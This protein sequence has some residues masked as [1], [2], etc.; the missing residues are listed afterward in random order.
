MAKVGAA[1]RPLATKTVAEKYIVVEIHSGAVSVAARA[2][3][4]VRQVNSP[5]L[6]FVKFTPN[7]V[8]ECTTSWQKPL[9]PVC[10]AENARWFA[11]AA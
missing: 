10:C 7:F 6:T 5:I 4:P 3:Q 11:L 9:N 2:R 1:V 8:Q